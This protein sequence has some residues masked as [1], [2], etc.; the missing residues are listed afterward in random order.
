MKSKPEEENLMEMQL[1]EDVILDL[2]PLYLGNA[3]SA[4]TRKLVEQYLVEPAN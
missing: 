4:Q 3:A 2:M 1:T